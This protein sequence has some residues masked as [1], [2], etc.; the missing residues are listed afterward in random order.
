MICFCLFL[1]ALV[2]LMVV[3]IL[4]IN[5]SIDIIYDDITALELFLTYVNTVAGISN[6]DTNH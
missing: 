4:C 2:L 5:L 6:R 3:I 1:V